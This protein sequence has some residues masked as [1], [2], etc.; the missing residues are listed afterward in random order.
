MKTEITATTGATQR[1]G[2]ICRFMAPRMG[3]NLQRIVKSQQ[4]TQ[5][6]AGQ[7]A[8]AC[9]TQNASMDPSG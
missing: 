5:V 1:Y 6:G 9:D 8:R 7:R 3:Q 2:A 4:T